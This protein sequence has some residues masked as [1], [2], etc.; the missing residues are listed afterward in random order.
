M[1]DWML[2]DVIHGGP[3]SRESKARVQG[4]GIGVNP[5]QMTR[6]RESMN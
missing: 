5:M 6:F 2:V 4:N 3:P 1:D